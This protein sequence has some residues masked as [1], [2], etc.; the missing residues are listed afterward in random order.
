MPGRFVFPLAALALLVMLAGCYNEVDG[1]ITDVD[2]GLPIADAQVGLITFPPFSLLPT[3]PEYTRSDHVGEYHFIHNE[4]DPWMYVWAPG[5][6]SQAELIPS[7]PKLTRNVRMKSIE[8]LI[9]DW[10]VSIT[11]DGQLFGQ[12]TFTFTEDG[13]EW[14]TTL[15]FVGTF[16]FDFDG[17]KVSIHD[18]LHDGG[19]VAGRIDGE[20]QLNDA[21]DRLGGSVDLSGVELGEGRLANKTSTVVEAVR[22][23]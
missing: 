23:D 1:K 16:R 17:S 3:F 13:I 2:S 20:L 9:G 18:E 19:G 4:R 14:A 15:G 21:G 8:A 11:I 6:L 12:A 5:Y 10:D 7:T 22:L